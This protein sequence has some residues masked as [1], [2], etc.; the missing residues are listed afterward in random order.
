MPKPKLLV[1][2]GYPYMI[3]NA[4]EPRYLNDFLSLGL[5]A[6]MQFDFDD[7]NGLAFVVDASYTP[8]RVN[9]SFERATRPGSKIIGETSVITSFYSINYLRKIGTYNN[10]SIKLLIG[11]AMGIY[12]LNFSE[13]DEN[14]SDISKK[15]RVRVR[16]IG[17]R[18][19]F[20]FEKKYS[21]NYFEIAGLYSLQDKYTR[22][23]NSELDAESVREVE[24]K[25][26]VK[27]WGIMFNLGVKLF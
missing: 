15:N 10:N 12:T 4:D 6:T 5:G 17:G 21:D 8:S 14:N 22:I 3:I 18:L 20:R 9:Y 23:N 13:V 26:F 16:N 25:V 7:N 1:H 24:N 11:P 2:V 19:G 27:T